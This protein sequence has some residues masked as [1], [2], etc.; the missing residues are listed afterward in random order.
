MA[1]IFTLYLLYFNSFARTAAIPADRSS[2]ASVRIQA[3]I[4]SDQDLFFPKGIYRIGRDI[5]INNVKNLKIRGEK[6][7]VFLTHGNKI[8]TISGNIHHL[9]ISGIEFVSRKVSTRDDSEGMIFIANYGA[10]DVMDGIR[11]SRCSF[12]NPRNHSN[13]IKLVSEGVNAVARN[14][15]VTYNTFR[16]IGR[17]GVEF[18]NHVTTL[19]RPRFRDFEISNN[20]FVDVGTIQL[21]PAPACISVSGYSLNGKIND[22]Q[23]SDMR[24]DTS[25][26]VYY[27]IENAGTINLETIGNQIRSTSFGFTGILG[28][29]PTED[30]SRATGQPLKGEWIIRNNLIMLRGSALNR[31]KIRGMEL[32]HVDGYVISN[33]TVHVDGYAMMFINC[34]NG[35]ISSNRVK[36]KAGNALYFKEGSTRNVITMNTLDSSEG[37]DHGVLMFYGP[38][39]KGNMAVNNK[40]VGSGGK[41]GKYVNYEG[42]TNNF[43]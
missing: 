8:I 24:M 26:F 11:I 2:D 42:A 9:E 1:L 13:A 39:T 23:I 6:G 17:M 3:L 21:H 15:S 10:R 18:Q 35:K 37:P 31:D 19:Q 14:I 36:V 5:Q 25:P 38:T 27:G 34:R 29:G 40:L 22:N 20:I 41:T 43:K 33:N 28:S 32:S 16:S 4:K 12:T 30:H 7:T